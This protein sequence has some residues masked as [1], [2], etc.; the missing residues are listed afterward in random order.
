MVVGWFKKI[1]WLFHTFWGRGLWFLPRLL[2]SGSRWSRRGFSTNESQSHIS[3]LGQVN[4]FCFAAALR[5]KAALDF[6]LDLVVAAAL[7]FGGGF[8][9]AA[10]LD[11]A[12]S[13]ALAVRSG[14]GRVDGAPIGLPV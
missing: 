13:S 7:G 5:F 1:G 8:F 12:A 3:K 6:A 4:T 2:H 14:S 11:F 9:F 10:T